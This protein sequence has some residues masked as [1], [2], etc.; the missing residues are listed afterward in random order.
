MDL[1]IL[2]GGMGSRFGGSKQ[3]ASIDDNQNFI[4]DYSIFDAF[5]VGF[6]RVVVVIKADQQEL[7]DS[8][9]GK[10]IPKEKVVYVHQPNDIIKEL[11]I[12]RIKPLG[13][14]HAV[15]SAKDVIKDNNFLMINAD[16]FYGRGAFKT[17]YDFLKK[18]DKN[19]ADFGIVGYSLR[20]T[21]SDFG[22]VKR[23]VCSIENG[24]VVG[25]KECQISENKLPITIK[26]L[27]GNEEIEYNADLYTNMNMFCLTP[28]IF[29]ELEKGFNEFKSVREKLEKDEFLLPVAISDLTKQ[30]KATLKLLKTTEKWIGMTYR[31]D[32]PFVKSAINDLVQKGIYP[33][34]LWN[35]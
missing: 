23:G 34:N 7:F 13:T 30:K 32:L 15:L 27:D 29:P 3:T 21:L 35:V 24:Y 17:A 20:N 25:M 12:D 10:R 8:T 11:K 26:T 6:D 4:M 33:K 1:L 14:A 19:K 22:S 31:E 28:A 9:I 5:K 16:D 2:A 18:A